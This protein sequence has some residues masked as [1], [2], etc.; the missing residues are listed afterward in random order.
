MANGSSPQTESGGWGNQPNNMA[1]LCAVSAATL[2][3]V[4]D[5]ISVMRSELVMMRGDRETEPQSKN[6]ADRPGI[7]Q[8][9]GV[10]TNLLCAS[11]VS[12][13]FN[14][15]IHFRQNISDM[16]VRRWSFHFCTSQEAQPCLHYIY[17]VRYF[18][19]LDVLS[20]SSISPLS[21]AFLPHWKL[22]KK[23]KAGGNR[24]HLHPGMLCMAPLN[25]WLW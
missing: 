4:W 20:S 15:L 3:A 6:Q 25:C 17:T 22:P 24:Q 10:K 2:R 5:E 13:I 8:G 21:E 11:C 19:E 1:N 23:W 7:G 16:L 12:S 18:M 9:F 14:S